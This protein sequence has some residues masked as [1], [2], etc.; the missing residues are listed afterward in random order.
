MRNNQIHKSLYLLPLTW[1]MVLIAGSCSVKPYISEGELFYAGVKEIKYEDKAGGKHGR[2][3][4]QDMENI[5]KY[6]PNNSLFQSA[7]T[8]L[9]LTYPF[10]INK[11]FGNSTNFFG[12]W[13]YKTFGDEPILIS[14]VSPSLRA[15]VAK[16]ILDE[17]GYFRSSVTPEVIINPKDSVSA[18][19]SYLISMGQPYLLDSISYQLNLLP[20]ALLDELLNPEERLIKKD[21]PFGVLPLENERTRL[22]NEL[23]GR[24]YYF[25]KPENIIYEADTVMAPGKVQL[26]VKL[27]EK[28]LPE[29]YRPWHIGTITYNVYDNNRSVLNDS[30]YHQGVLFRFNKKSPVRLGVLRPRVRIH[31]D[32]LYNQIYQNRTIQS[33]AELNTFAYT[34]VSYQPV[35]RFDS[36]GNRLNV[37]INSQ[38]DRPYFTELEGTWKF[39][40]NNQ[41]G[42]G[43]AFSINRKNIF[44]GGELFSVQA[45]GSYEWETK[46][47][48][49]EKSWNIN[50]YELGLTTSLTFPRILLPVL[51]NRPLNFPANTRLSIFGT[52]LNRG[53]FYRQAKFGG[54]L[55]YRFEPNEFVRHIITPISLSYN[56]LLRET[57]RFREAIDANPILALS[58]QNQFIP[59]WNYLFRYERQNYLSKHGFSIETYFAEAGGLLSLFYK[60]KTRIDGSPHKVLGAPFAQFLKGTIELRYNYRITNH[61]QV[62]SRAYAGMVW[63]YGNMQVAPYTEQFYVGGANSIRGFNVRSV[64]PGSYVP[65]TDDALNF[66]DRAGDLRLEANIE[67]RYNVIGDLELATF[68]DAGNIWL[69]R[70]EEHR[71]NGHLTKEYFLKDV[72]L[73]TGLGLR[74]NLMNY[75]VFRFDVGLALHHPTRA[76][77]KYFNTFGKD[78]GTPLAFHFAIGYPF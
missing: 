54:D 61:L 58:F 7:S 72:A 62:A 78:K 53:T 12:R 47:T 32:S 41:T 71:P 24:G 40:S 25:F 26:R 75:L 36:L 52:I 9:P 57:D 16:Q 35:Y 15:T 18:R 65:S 49:K 2:M 22:T 48:S 63:S 45:H 73:G 64:G 21:D 67:L 1:L 60:G 5:L 43:A 13:L 46:R 42:P 37:V 14:T 27:S 31:T 70:P 76:K 56:H 59:Q 51:A 4:V 8:R 28:T 23:R 33:M 11:H 30:V 39:K 38:L 3:T 77:E 34:D 44:R 50:S 29:A 19:V 6:K 55:T 68:I 20:P 69:T 17:Y 10:Y 66:L 74:Y